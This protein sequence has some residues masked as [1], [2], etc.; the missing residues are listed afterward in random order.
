MNEG[1]AALSKPRWGGVR[2]DL[3]RGDIG[4]AEQ[5]LQI[6]DAGPAFQQMGDEGVAHFDDQM[7]KPAAQVHPLS[8][9]ICGATA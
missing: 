5:I 3:R 7:G 4:M 1:Q 8:L 2:L 6:A 9:S